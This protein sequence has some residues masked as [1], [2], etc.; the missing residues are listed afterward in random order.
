VS[1]GFRPRMSGRLFLGLCMS[2]ALPLPFAMCLAWWLEEAVG[3][4]AFVA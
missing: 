1:V 4:N 2:G 3:D